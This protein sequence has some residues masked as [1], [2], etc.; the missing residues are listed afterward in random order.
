MTVL[1]QQRLQGERAEARHL[2]RPTHVRAQRAEEIRQQILVT[3]G[4]LDESE[5]ATTK[6]DEVTEEGSEE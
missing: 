5:V 6:T 3:K 2:E 4:L 1:E